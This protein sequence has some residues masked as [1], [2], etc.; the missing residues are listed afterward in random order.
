LIEKDLLN[1]PSKVA[2]QE[3]TKKLAKNLGYKEKKMSNPL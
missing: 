1:A 3:I 2:F